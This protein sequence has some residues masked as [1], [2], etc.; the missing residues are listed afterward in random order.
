MSA[1]FFEKTGETVSRARFPNKM[2]FSAKPRNVRDLTHRVGQQYKYKKE[3]AAFW[4]F[5]FCPR[6]SNKLGTPQS[7][8]LW[9]G[10]GFHSLPRSRNL[11][12]GSVARPK[13]ESQPYDSIRREIQTEGTH[14][15]KSSYSSIFPD[16]G[17]SS[18]NHGDGSVAN[19][20]D[21]IG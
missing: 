6:G 16:C 17:R 18:P 11:A 8:N 14:E 20:S 19:R 3:K 12:N 9:E 2:P 10:A 4:N 15:S 7:S 13:F 21:V 1:K 5:G